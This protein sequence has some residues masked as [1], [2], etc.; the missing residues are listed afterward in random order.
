MFR[1]SL[2]KKTGFYTRDKVVILC[3]GLPFYVSTKET[4]FNLP[5]GTYEVEQGSIEELPKPIV[6]IVPTLPRPT[7]KSITPKKLKIIVEPNPHKCTFDLNKGT[8]RIDPAFI[9]KGKTFLAFI[10]GHEIG[11]LNYLGSKHDDNGELKCDKYSAKM[12][13]D[14]GYN[15]SQLYFA[16][17]LCLTHSPERKEQFEN[18]LKQIK[19]KK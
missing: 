5:S 6:Y 1:F 8:V 13:I 2:D 9:D 7:R 19:V 11:H 10:F 18:F 15:P 12:L 4:T 3:H 17:N 16:Q 14:E